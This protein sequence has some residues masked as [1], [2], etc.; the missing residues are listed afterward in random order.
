MCD[1]LEAG[2]VRERDGTR[3]EEAATRTPDPLRTMAIH[4]GIMCKMC[5]TVHFIATSPSI[6]ASKLVAGMYRLTC[7]RP[8]S[9]PQSLEKKA[10]NRTGSRKMSS[11]EG[12]QRRASTNSSDKAKRFHL[13]S[14]LEN[15]V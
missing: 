10:C 9:L 8:F 5:R 1:T 13:Y 6:G 15:G 11:K 14:A 7:R 3:R 12:M 4:M 2:V